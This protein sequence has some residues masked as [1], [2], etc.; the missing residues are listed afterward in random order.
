M[1]NK[2]PVTKIATCDQN[3][4]SSTRGVLLIPCYYSTVQIL[5]GNAVAE[6][7]NK[8]CLTAILSEMALE[9]EKVGI[10]GRC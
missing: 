5:Y 6:P 9:V 7:F 2:G 3:P 8:Y 4:G 1:T 10:G